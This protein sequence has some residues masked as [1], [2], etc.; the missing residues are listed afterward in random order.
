MEAGIAIGREMKIIFTCEEDD[1]KNNRKHFDV[2]HYPFLTY[3]S[4]EELTSKLKIEIAAY[5]SS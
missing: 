3:K 4:Y 2:N 5:I 1:F